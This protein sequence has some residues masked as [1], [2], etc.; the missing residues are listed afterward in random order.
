MWIN[1]SVFVIAVL[2]GIS[3]ANPTMAASNRGQNEAVPPRPASDP[4]QW[5]TADDYPTDA[6]NQAIE[7]R[8]VVAVSVD[9][10]GNPTACKA[11]ESSGNAELDS[12]ACDKILERAH[13]LPAKDKRGRP[14]V[15][16]WRN[17]VVWK[18]APSGPPAPGTLVRSYI[19]NTDGSVTDCRIEAAE[20]V[21]VGAKAEASKAFCPADAE[22]EPLIGADG[23]PVRKRIR[24]TMRIE[25]EDVP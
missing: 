6:A 4:A 24:I 21:F 10:R 20:G 5:V 2:V 13:F 25:Q 23:N 16:E 18:L 7:G 8:V 11:V 17:G 1:R 12:T 15:S 14:V 3:A 9:E 19:V 22:M